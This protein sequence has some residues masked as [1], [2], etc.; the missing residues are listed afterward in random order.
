LNRVEREEEQVP[1]RSRK[2][3]DGRMGK[4]GWDR[5]AQKVVARSYQKK[6]KKRKQT[7]E[8]GEGGFFGLFVQG[9]GKKK[10][11]KRVLVPFLG[12]EKGEKAKKEGLTVKRVDHHLPHHKEKKKGR[13]NPLYNAI[14]GRGGSLRWERRKKKG[15][16]DFKQKKK[17]KGEKEPIIPIHKEKKRKDGSRKKKKSSSAWPK[18]IFYLEKRKKYRKKKREKKVVG[19]SRLH[20]EG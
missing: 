5:P 13:K 1:C 18:G 19:G 12:E 3:S 6:K 9:G 14:E 10:K 11:K 17:R 16:L 4:K 2:K 8:K 7:L 20:R 15:F